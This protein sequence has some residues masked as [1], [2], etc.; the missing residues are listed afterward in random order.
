MR[1]LN[2]IPSLSGGGAEKQLSYLAPELARRKH[3][4][5]IAYTKDGPNKPELPGVTLHHI[6][7]VS[8]YDPFLFWQIFRLIRKIKPDIVQT[9]IVQ[10]DIIGGTAAYLNGVHWLLREPSSILAYPPTWKNRL[11]V[12]I[13]STTSAIVSN[14]NGGNEYWKLKLPKVPQFTVQNA[15]P[16]DEIDK[17]S[18]TDSLTGL[19]TNNIPIVLYVG[20]LASDG[21]ATKNLRTLL[22]ALFYVKQQKNVQ[23]ILCGN[24]PQKAEL[25]SLRLQLKLEENVHFTG[26]LPSFMVWELMKK[27][28]VF[29]S[30]SKYEG[31]PNAVME[32]MAC[33]CPLILSDIPSHREILDENSALFVASSDVQHIASMIVHSLSDKEHSKRRA[34]NAKIK[35]TSWSINATAAKWENVYQQ[36]VR[37]K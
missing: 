34:E 28:S 36:V 23:G 9:W 13:A 14:S 22:E 18:T 6:K 3:D 11:R 4:I 2:L 35:T 37:Y 16:L 30:L 17:I 1:I 31:C 32:A 24:G 5:H 27:A 25:E 33:G 29:I 26:H 15:L 20:R 8:N 12:L 19:L 21:S 7:S 10:M